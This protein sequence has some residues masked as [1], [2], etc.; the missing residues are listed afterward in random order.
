[1]GAAGAAIVAIVLLAFT[2]PS[3]SIKIHNIP[4]AI[5]GSQQIVMGFEEGIEQKFPGAFVFDTV[6]SRTEAETQIAHREDFGA[7]LFD[8]T[9]LG[10][11]VLTVPA[12]S[13]AVAQILE[14]V[15]LGIRAQISEHVAAAGG[16]VSKVA[17]NVSPLISLSENDT[18]GSGIVSA[19]F[20]MVLGGIIGGLIA[21]FIIRG[22][23]NKL[24][25]LATFSVAASVFLTLILQSWFGFLQGNFGLNLLAIG[26]SVFAT[27]ALIGGLT[28]AIGRPG[29]ALGAGFT[30][31]LANPIS[32]AAT[33]WQ[34]LAG[35][36]GQI[37]QYLV[38]GA[39]NYLL[40]SLSYFPDADSSMQWF[41]LVIW[42][43]AGLGLLAV[44]SSASRA[45]ASK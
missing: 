5:S 43:V 44:T 25:F 6:A 22:R 36:F 38:P 1:M 41:T 16:D 37:G 29:L 31:L 2:W 10:A 4:I 23:R 26:V 30:M 34:F 11:T 40:R 35:P 24:A 14:K 7:I 32:A 13:P 3:K 39:S 15:G 8:Q 19:A 12:A 18:T 45:Q 33:P 9:G 20:P 42:S 28:N 27:A 17:V 21:T